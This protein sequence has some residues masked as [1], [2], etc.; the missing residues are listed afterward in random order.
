LPGRVLIVS[1]HFPPVNA[2]D[3]QRV[4]MSLPYLSEFGWEA[5]ILAVDPRFVEGFRDP[6]LLQTVP[7]DIP[8]TRVPALPAGLT[9]RVG[10]GS[11]G[12]R[13]LGPLSLA[14]DRLLRSRRF[15]LVYFSTTIF[16]AMG[17]GP[18]WKRRWGVPYILDMQDPWISDYYDRTGVRPPGGRLKY[19]FAQWLARRGEP[20]AMRGAA[21]VISVSPDY[22]AALQRRYPELPADRFVVLPFGGSERDAE[23]VLKQGIR[24][25]VFDP[26]DGLVHWTYLGRGGADMAIAL[27]G[28]FLALGRVRENDPRADRLRLHFVGTSYAGRGRGQPTVAPLARDAGIGDLVQEQTDRIPYLEGLALLRTSNA[29]LIIGSD[30]PAYSASKVYPCIL[31]GRPLLAVLHRASLAGDVIRQCNA[32]STVGF[33]SGGSAEELSSRIEPELLRLLDLP[34]AYIPSTDRAAFAPYTAREMTRQQ[35]AVFDHAVKNRRR[36]PAI[37]AAEV[38]R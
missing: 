25:S 29:V 3:F 34:P 12:L 19:A 21:R 26:D 36:R 32:G 16:P 6:A 24:H 13:A 1:P 37:T 27:R 2:P 38:C 4:R 5:H 7:D 9:R 20:T 33:E 10:L 28:L 8:V 23:I 15:D 31:A 30:D 22:P 35:C 17:L 18:V 14:G 11:L